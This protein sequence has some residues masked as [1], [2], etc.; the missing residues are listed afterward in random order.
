LNDI[1]DLIYVDPQW[2]AI[3]YHYEIT[4][5]AT[6][7]IANYY[8]GSGSWAFSFSWVKGLLYDS[9]YVMR[10]RAN[11]NGTWSVFSD[12]CTYTMPPFPA[13]QLKAQY[14]DI[15]IPSLDY[16]MEVVTIINATDYY[17]TVTDSAGFSVNYY[18]NSTSPLINLKWIP[19][20]S[21]G[22]TYYIGVQAM[23]GSTF[24]PMGIIC[25]VTIPSQVR[26]INNDARIVT[27]TINPNPNT[28]TGFILK[29]S[30]PVKNELVK[31]DI[32]D[33]NGRLVFNR[34]YNSEM[35][36]I[37]VDLKNQ[38]APGL[39]TVSVYYSNTVEHI[40]LIIQK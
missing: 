21:A 6:G 17:Y 12:P 38:L 1:K 33:L 39:Y 34:Y 36:N 26:F 22:G 18:R 9:T 32:Y 7:F 30:N 29:L 40:K 19:G 8:R 35:D 10:Y 28:G 20:I 23:Q 37:Y 3:N 14:C 16:L 15:T 24:G 2:G 25:A 4:H 5:P 13:T 31:I 27:S 11:I